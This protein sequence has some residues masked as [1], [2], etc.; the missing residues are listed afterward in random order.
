M[1]LV[2]CP[3]CGPRNQSDLRLLGASVTRPD[4]ETTT[5][6]EWGDYL[7]LRDN[8]ADWIKESWY[9]RSGCRRYFLLER[10]QATN[11]F[12]NP[13]LPGDKLGTST[14]TTIS[15]G[16]S[17]AQPGDNSTASEGRTS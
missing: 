11:E 6:A 10:H 15:V 16:S 17:G 1:L 8:P 2:P 5:R 7:Y 13:P 14:Y 9:C 12:R 4:P 3:N